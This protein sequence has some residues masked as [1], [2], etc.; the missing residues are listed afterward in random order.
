MIIGEH[1][2]RLRRQAE[3]GDVWAQCLLGEIFRKGSGVVRDHAEA[4]RW[5]RMAAKRQHRDAEYIVG[6]MYLRG[7]GVPE[8]QLVAFD[9]MQRAASGGQPAACRMLGRMYEN[10]VGV[11][12]DLENARRYKQAGLGR[13]RTGYR[14]GMMDKDGYWFRGAE[15][16]D[17][18][19]GGGLFLMTG[20]VDE[21]MCG[22]CLR[23]VGLIRTGDEWRTIQPSVFE[24]SLHDGCR[25]AWR[26]VPRVNRAL[27]EM[28]SAIRYQVDIQN[29]KRGIYWR[30]IVVLGKRTTAPFRASPCRRL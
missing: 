17:F 26:H 12:R 27:D 6:M 5:Y 14:H 21:Q 22:G 18:K 8:D 7:E 10:G 4:M 2:D 15:A 16:A 23:H 19:T 20:P 30:P 3:A 1:L 11:H 9:W 28:Q 25:C 24:T 13:R 29:Y